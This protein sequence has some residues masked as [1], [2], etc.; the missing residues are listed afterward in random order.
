MDPKNEHSNDLQSAVIQGNRTGSKARGVFC[1][2]LPC[3]SDKSS[4]II[5][6]LGSSL[7]PLPTTIHAAMSQEQQQPP[8][9]DIPGPA[10][11]QGMNRGFLCS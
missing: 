3:L 1:M 11:P 9:N 4:I 10:G 6:G 8:N 2:I 5:K 7:H